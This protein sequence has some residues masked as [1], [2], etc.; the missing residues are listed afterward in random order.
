[1][2][3]AFVNELLLDGSNVE[4][5]VDSTFSPTNGIERCTPAIWAQYGGGLTSTGPR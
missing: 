1:M 4:R 5:M 2:L 3:S